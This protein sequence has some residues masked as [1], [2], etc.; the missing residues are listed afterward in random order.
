[1]LRKGD[2]I[3]LV[4]IK[5]KGEI[6]DKLELSHQPMRLTLLL[7]PLSESEHSFWQ[8]K[9]Q[10][11]GQFHGAAGFSLGDIVQT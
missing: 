8:S 1:M 11:L 2:V 9:V 4:L 3:F 10:M 7:L 5:S 6:L